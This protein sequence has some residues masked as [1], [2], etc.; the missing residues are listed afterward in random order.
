MAAESFLGYEC[1]REEHNAQRSKNNKVVLGNGALGAG[2]SS[3][4]VAVDAPG[5]SMWS[6]GGGYEEF[7]LSSSG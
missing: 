6:W 1:D 4:G 5:C 2:I 3:Y 7:Q